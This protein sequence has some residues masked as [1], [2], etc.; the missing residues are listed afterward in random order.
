MT[1]TRG[2]AGNLRLLPPAGFTRIRHRRHLCLVAS[3]CPSKPAG[4]NPADAGLGCL[5]SLG[6]QERGGLSPGLRWG[7]PATGC[8]GAGEGCPTP[9]RGRRS[10]VGT[11]PRSPSP[12]P[13]L[14][15]TSFELSSLPQAA[16]PV[17][18]LLGISVAGPLGC[19]LSTAPALPPRP[20]RGF[21]ART[22]TQ[23]VAERARHLTGRTCRAGGLAGT[24]LPGGPAAL[25]PALPPRPPV[26]RLRLPSR[27]RRT[28]LP[29]RANA[30]ALAVVCEGRRT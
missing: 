27:V 1:G 11:C 2:S 30:S 7:T 19:V 15:T 4:G 18:P 16:S 10:L 29:L 26:L 6:D 5:G 24:W 9:G 20:L 21:P 8:G 25:G 22:G 14:P 12:N 28:T 23:L 17:F 3:S 13:I